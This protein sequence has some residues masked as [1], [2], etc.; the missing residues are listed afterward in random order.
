MTVKGAGVGGKGEG[1]S[2][3]MNDTL[4][5]LRRE[6]LSSNGVSQCATAILGPRASEQKLGEGTLFRS[7]CLRLGWTPASSPSLTCVYGN[8]ISLDAA[9]HPVRRILSLTFI[10]RYTQR[11]MADRL[12]ERISRRFRCAVT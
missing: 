10:Y 4:T 6:E 1:L 3:G 9:L 5:S 8:R 7:S 2:S 12:R 11:N